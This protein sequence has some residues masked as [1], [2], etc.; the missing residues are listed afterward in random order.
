MKYVEE[1]VPTKYQTKNFLP[2]CS[3]TCCVW[4]VCRTMAP[5]R[6][7]QEGLLARVNFPLYTL[8]MLTSRHVLV[9]GG[10]GSSNTGVAN[11]FVSEYDQKNILCCL[12]CSI[13]QTENHSQL[14]LLNCRKFSSS[15]MMEK[16]LLQ[17]RLYVMKLV[18]VL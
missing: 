9:G 11:G 10:G 15:H 13:L 2:W 18:R 16:N 7:K 14:V 8:Q 17:R 3:E 12:P 5:I 4:N 1:E 6:R